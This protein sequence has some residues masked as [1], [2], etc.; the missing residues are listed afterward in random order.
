MGPYLDESGEHSF[1]FSIVPTPAGAGWRA[2]WQRAVETN[3][4]QHMRLPAQ[5]VRLPCRAAAAAQPHEPSA[6]LPAAAPLLQTG[7]PRLWVS[8][9]KKEDAG[10][11]VVVRLFD[12]EGANASASLRLLSA[13]VVRASR[14]SIIE[15]EAELLPSAAQLDVPAWGIETFKL[16]PS[17]AHAEQAS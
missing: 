14:T 1:H 8:A 13:P 10:S 6:T 4:A 16:E 7:H 12:N 15:H 11:G 9:V 2:A 17:W 3:S 5:P